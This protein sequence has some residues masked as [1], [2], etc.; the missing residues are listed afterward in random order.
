[1]WNSLFRIALLM[2][3]F[4]SAY[5]QH[6]SVARQWNEVL[7]TAIRNDLARPTV[8]ARNLFHHSAA[9]YDALAVSDEEAKTYFLGNTLD[10][11]TFD[12]DPYKWQPLRFEKFNHHS[13]N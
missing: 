12:F 9:M 1:M 8:H 2:V 7:L 4:N 5:G 13:G 10:R 6:H 3:L 11:F